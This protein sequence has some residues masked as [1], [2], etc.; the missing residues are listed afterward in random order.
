MKNKFTK[1][2]IFFLL[3]HLVFAG[4]H[5]QSS[6]QVL[7]GTDVL[8]SRK[9]VEDS[10]YRNQQL[11]FR[12]EIQGIIEN[13]K[14]HA[15]Q[16]TAKTKQVFTIPLVFHVLH[17]GESIGTGTNVSDA[18]IQSAVA[19]MNDRFRGVNGIG[20]DTEI[21]F[22]LAV[23]DPSGCYTTGINRVNASN[24][25]NYPTKGIS[26]NNTCGAVDEYVLK[27]LSKWTSYYYY[28]VWVVNLIDCSTLGASGFA[29]P[30]SGT[31]Y[32]GTVILASALNSVSSTL[33]HELGHGLGLWH[34]FEGDF[35]NAVCPTNSN[36]LTDGDQICDTPPHKQSDCG[37]SNPCTSS[38]NWDNSKDNYMSY[39]GQQNRFTADQKM[40]MRATF[41]GFPRALLLLSKGC[42]P[43]NF[44]SLI[45]KTDVSCAGA[46]DGT[47]TIT[48]T[49]AST[50]TYSWSNGNS[51]NAQSGLCGGTYTLTIT[52]AT[53][54][55]ATIPVTIAE[56]TA[57]TATPVVN[58][59]SCNGTSDGSISLHV[60]GG[61]PFTCGSNFTVGIG[62]G[63]VVSSNTQYPAPFGNSKWG[64]KNQLFFHQSEI[65]T[66]GFTSGKIQSVSLHV[67]SISGTNSYKN[68]EIQMKAIP[69]VGS[70]T[71]MQSGLQTVFGPQTVTINTGW[72]TF[73][74]TN[75]LQW[76]GATSVLLQ[77]CFNDTVSTFNSPVY[78]STTAF[79]SVVYVAKDSVGVCNLLP[80]SSISSFRRPNVRFGVCNDSLNYQ[81]QWSNGQTG[82]SITGLDTGNYAVTVRDANGCFTT[83]MNTVSQNIATA[84]AGADA[85]IFLGNTAVLGGNPTATGHPPYT[86]SWSPSIG[87][88][89]VSVSNPLATPAVTTTYSVA[90]TDSSFCTAF[91]TV[92]VFVSTGTG[93]SE[94]KLKG[95]IK[96][97]AP[98]G[99]ENLEVKSDAI[100]NGLYSIQI[101]N[102]LGKKCYASEISLVN[103]VMN[104]KISTAELKA[105]FYIVSV[106]A[107]KEVEFVKICRQ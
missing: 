24:I 11:A 59:T 84:D 18:Q 38:G 62:N 85:F 9:M 94:P 16:S 96:V 58:G 47:V 27:D 37:T 101:F 12:K 56:P 22:C 19:A 21:E 70:L 54:V 77:F 73:Y 35:G 97:Y 102:A 41:V 60:S 30:P 78:C 29:S 95:K 88:N 33:T 17:L 57:I 79:K 8:H 98:D 1:A 106:T 40:R 83:S 26:L 63:T 74:F 32:D 43:S 6:A 3:V 69:N 4:L 52:D 100:L 50:Y 99:E 13:Q 71:V 68:F 23:Q 80:A 104:H 15:L 86:Y 67:A 72:N 53:N 66:A 34:T 65:Q 105:G 48:P 10:L 76:N 25:P 107:N 46:C 44:A 39:C 51:T 55:T 45:S 7:C 20:T 5:F 75:P 49:C 82:N 31:P 42:S 64:A 36:C 2:K 81:Y 103:Q 93:I 14:L 61:V 90:I 28:N 87:L 91:D 92:T 89:A